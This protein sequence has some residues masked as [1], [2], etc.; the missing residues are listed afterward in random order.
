[1]GGTFEAQPMNDHFGDLDLASSTANESQENEC[2]GDCRNGAH[3]AGFPE[4]QDTSECPK[5][6][7]IDVWGYCRWVHALF[8]FFTIVTLQSIFLL[9]TQGGFTK[10]K[11]EIGNGG[12]P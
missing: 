4:E 2:G 3:Q 10:M 5:G 8:I 6:M 9:L 11:A 7:V 12:L 1:M